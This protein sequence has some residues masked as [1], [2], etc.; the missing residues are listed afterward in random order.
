MVWE[1]VFLCWL[2]KEAISFFFVFL[3]VNVVA[4]AV[5]VAALCVCG[6]ERI[7]IYLERFKLSLDKSNERSRRKW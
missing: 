2:Y 4:V 7:D 6:V 1:R 5:A 3:S